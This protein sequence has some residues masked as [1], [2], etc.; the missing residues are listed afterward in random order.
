M[1]DEILLT[2]DDTT[3]GK[4]IATYFHSEREKNLNVLYCILSDEESWNDVI[5]ACSP[6]AAKWKQLSGFMG[7]SYKT[8]CTIDNNPDDSEGSW[9]EALMQW[10]LQKYNTEKYGLPSWK[11]LL[12]TVSRVDQLLFEKLAKEHQAKGECTA[13]HNVNIQ[14]VQH[15][16]QHTLYSWYRIGFFAGVVYKLP[17]Y[18]ILLK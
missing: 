14:L 9:N 1:I 11:S 6:L 7:L 12:K 5:I 4:S 8:I 16:T 15:D 13:T 10:I 3:F 17:L 2:V 18:I